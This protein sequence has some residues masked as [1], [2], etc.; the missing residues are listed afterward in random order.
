M[1]RRLLLALSFCLALSTATPA[2]Q[3]SKSAT[4]DSY[5]R[6]YQ[7]VEE[8][9]KALG[10]VEALRAAED[11]WVK[12]SGSTWARNQSLK[13]GGPWDQMTRD[14][15]LFADFRRGRYTFENRDPLPGGF[16]FGGKV[17]V[18]GGQAFS[19]TTSA[20]AALTDTRRLASGRRRVRSTWR[21]RSRST[22][23]L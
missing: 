11:V 1:Q 14:E 4:A 13:V 15:T 7:T 18:S 16:V 17:V 10:G 2:R 23:S 9:L 12:A 20:Q 19:T 5:R 3:A 8:G 22:M 6:A 21:S